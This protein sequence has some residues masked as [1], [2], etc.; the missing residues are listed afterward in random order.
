MGRSEAIAIATAL[1]EQW[2]KE[3]DGELPAMKARGVIMTT[4]EASA[5]EEWVVR[6]AL[7]DALD[8]ALAGIRV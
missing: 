1:R 2:E 7:L 3:G 6:K 5:Y 4:P 8:R